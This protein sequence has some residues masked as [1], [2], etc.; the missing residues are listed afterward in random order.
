MSEVLLDAE[1]GE[2]LAET[3]YYSDGF[4][5]GRINVADNSI[6]K[7]PNELVKE[8]ST[9]FTSKRADVRKRLNL[10]SYLTT[11]RFMDCIMQ[12]DLGAKASLSACMAKN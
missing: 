10:W 8:L 2:V 5:I 11:Q 12:P 7:E 4:A 1:R 9:A 6:P 3:N